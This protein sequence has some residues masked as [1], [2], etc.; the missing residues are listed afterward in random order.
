MWDNRILI[1]VNGQKLPV[2]S[3]YDPCTRLIDVLR[4]ETR[5]KVIQQPVSKDDKDSQSKDHLWTVSCS[6]TCMHAAS[7]AP[8]TS[9]IG[10]WGPLKYQCHCSEDTIWRCQSAVGDL[11]LQQSCPANST[12]ATTAVILRPAR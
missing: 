4:S 3:H 1:S 2:P 6:S 11:R 8:S 10:V 7:E 5:F 12:C 9:H